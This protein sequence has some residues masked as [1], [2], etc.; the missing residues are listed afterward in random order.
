MQ[1][2]CWLTYPQTSL[3]LYHKG[4][5]YVGIKGNLRHQ[6]LEL[7]HHSPLG[8]HSGINATYV[9][10]SRHFYWPAMLQQVIQLVRSCEVC[11][12]CKS[13]HVASPGLLQPLPIPAKAWQYVT[14]DFVEQLPKSKGKDAMLVVICRFTKYGHFLALQHPFSAISIAKLFFEFVVKLHEIP[15]SIISDRN[16]I[17]TS[18]FWKGLFKLMGT[19]L[20]YST[21]YHP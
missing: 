3:L 17:F 1:T 21:T 18:P 10:I 4:K 5:L 19:K 2:S 13:E 12:R 7:Y 9:S 16:Q 14:R 6:L 11:V 8:G 15:K 20:A